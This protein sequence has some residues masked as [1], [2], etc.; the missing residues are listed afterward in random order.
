MAAWMSDAPGSPA[1]ASPAGPG[2]GRSLRIEYL[3]VLLLA[4]L[5]YWLS[6][7][8]GMLWQDNGMAQIRAMTGDLTGER[9]LALSH[10]LFYLV[11][12]AFQRI[13]LGEP[14]FRVTL[15]AVVFGALTVA[16]LYLLLRQVAIATQRPP[17]APPDRS[18]AVAGALSLAVAHTFWQH[19][20]MAE[21]YTLY[22]AVL[23]TELLLLARYFQSPA[24]RWLALLFLVNGL[25]VSV[26][27][28]AL[29]D[30][31]VIGSLLVWLAVRRRVRPAWTALCGLAWLA[32][33]SIYLALVLQEWARGVP[34][35]TVVHSALFGDFAHHVLNVH[36]TARMLLNFVLY[37]GLNFPTPVALLAVLGLLCLRRLQSRP[38]AACIAGLLAIHALWLV[39]YDIVDQY[40]FF[41]PTIVLSAVLTG[42]GA[43]DFLSHHGR[44][45][46]AGVLVGCL[47]P[48][49]VYAALPA[50]VS[51]LGLR[52]LVPSRVVP[53]RD[54]LHYYLWPWKTGYR[55]PERLAAEIHRTLPD[56][57]YLLADSTSSWAMHY[58]RLRGRWTKDITVWPPIRWAG[59]REDRRYEHLAPWLAA[60]KLY[61]VAP[62]RAYCPAWLLAEYDFEPAGI[63]F[64]VRGPRGSTS[65]S[66][67]P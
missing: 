52:S 18:P 19:S 44:T 10:P 39:R 9:G 41:I 32:G 38:L 62:H 22:S 51:G 33:A 56:G 16:N 61:A 35:G 17:L 24:P 55:G 21:T 28:L 3:V 29:L 50:V 65:P 12:F 30:L 57:A 53:F 31:A 13:P 59:D 14:A 54:E 20:A 37:L 25:G 26:H 46:R 67:P 58:L 40:T 27:L 15:V 47:L 6:A 48:V 5:L 64:R 8:P 43:A 49:P 66:V 1:C 7:A 45:A 4:L 60:G 36:L 2:G 63:V 42:L 34:L 11:A 23:T